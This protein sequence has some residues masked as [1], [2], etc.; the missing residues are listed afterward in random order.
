MQTWRSDSERE[1]GGTKQQEQ[2]LVKGEYSE[3]T[4][5]HMS[6]HA[7]YQNALSQVGRQTDNVCKWLL[8]YIFVPVG[9]VKIVNCLVDRRDGNVK[10]GLFMNLCCC[11]PWFNVC[12]FVASKR[13]LNLQAC[14][15][16]RW[17]GDGQFALKRIIK[18]WPITCIVIQ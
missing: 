12:N 11:S 15:I 14:K 18:E 3:T 1:G 2:L 16:A 9:P 6:T 8:K 4:R 10:K 13:V 17:R 5:I 7:V